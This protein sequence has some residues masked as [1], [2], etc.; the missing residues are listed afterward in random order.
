MLQD[1]SGFIVT[2][3]K[4]QFNTYPVNY[5]KMKSSFKSPVILLIMT[6]AFF[7]SCTATSYQNYPDSRVEQRE[8]NT[9]LNNKRL[10]KNIDKYAKELEL[11]KGQVR[12]LK[13]IDR[14]YARK[15]RKLKSRE[16]AKRRDIRNLQSEKREM[17]LSLLT[18]KQQQ[19][20]Q[21]LTKS[22][23]FNFFGLMDNL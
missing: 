13:Q 7:A 9:A 14:R 19:K 10:E 16:N 1:S 11:S 2:I 5:P 3:L 4:I 8:N 17:M 6:L 22:R 15:E 20:L 21:D 23:K 18:D 12:K